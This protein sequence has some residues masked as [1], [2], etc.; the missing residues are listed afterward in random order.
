MAMP[1]V[2]RVEVS[3]VLI[4]GAGI[5]GLSVALSLPQCTILTRGPLGQGGS[6]AW[7]QGGIAAAVDEAD[8]AADHARDTLKA[9]GG[10]VD[11]QAAERLTEGGK[12]AIR[13]LIELGAEF[14][15]DDHGELALSREGGHGRR[16]VVHAEG[17]ATGAEILR[18]LTTASR[19]HSGIRLSPE[20]RAIDLALHHGRVVGVLAEKPS[21]ARILHL[22]PAVVLATGGASRIFSHT[23][24]PPESIGDGAAMAARAGAT[25]GDMEFEQFHPTALVAGLDPLPLLTEALRGEGATLINELGERFM[26]GQHPDAELAPR[27]VVA[28]A[29][30]SQLQSG[31]QVF[32]DSRKVMR[33]SG[34]ERFSLCRLAAEAAGIDPNQ[35][36]LPVSPAA[37]YHVGGVAVDLDGR[38]SLP[39]L[40]AVGEATSTGV[41]GAN[42]LASNSLLEGVVFGVAAARSIRG[43]QLSVEGIRGVDLPTDL[44]RLTADPQPD[45]VASIRA[46]M[47]EK[48]GLI[49]DED[50]LKGAI[51][52]LG[53]VAE[54]ATS[55]E[56]RNLRFVA[57]IVARAALARQES[58]GTHFRADFP[59]PNPDLA[60]RSFQH[61]IPV[62]TET[63]SLVEGVEV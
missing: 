21:G 4:V 59:S 2:D 20:S 6:T 14:D 23:T 9:G 19:K 44:D 38:S 39:G 29:I 49:R 11:A 24:N 46:T 31:H 18:A 37:H 3:P 5:A 43:S 47:W 52:E 42:R 26:P 12:E 50:G 32:L 25:L 36:P 16:R 53:S 22:A 62:P 51:E 17:D 55:L 7:A 27:D 15:F 28:R 60:K 13:W 45:L 1:N 57:E 56:A 34:P 30:W 63:V 35:E 61:F 40:W 10:I 54:R 33:E 58:R 8:S 48:V 41:H